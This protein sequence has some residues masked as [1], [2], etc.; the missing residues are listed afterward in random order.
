MQ[1][2]QPYSFLLLAYLLPAILLLYLLKRRYQDRVISS[3][4][5]WQ[6]LFEDLE[7]NRPWKK[8][9]HHLLLWLQLLVAILLVF[10]LSRPSLPA[11]TIRTSS[12]IIVIDISG[13]MLAKEGKQT[14]LEIARQKV[15]SFIDHK[16][17]DQQITLIAAGRVPRLLISQ[18]D[19]ES[20]LMNVLDQLQPELGS[21]DLD[22]ALSFA[23]ALTTATNQSEIL[24]VSDG[25]SL[26]KQPAS[27][28]HRS[29]Q[30]GSAKPNVAI[31]ASSL[32]ENEGKQELFVRV[33]QYG[34][35]KNQVA[36]SVHDLQGNLLAT[37]SLTMENETSQEVH[38]S[39]LPDQPVYQLDI[40]PIYDALA[41]DN[42]RYQMKTFQ[43]KYP[44]HMLG[45]PSIFLQKVFS[46]SDQLELSTNPLTSNEGF[47]VVNG[48]NQ[49]AN[50]PALYFSTQ[51]QGLANS[52]SSIHTAVSGQIE[53]TTPHMIGEGL[54]FGELSVANLSPVR[55]P[56]WADVILQIEGKPL[57]VA[58]EYQGK[59]VVLF[60]FD[61]EKSDLALKPYFPVLMMQIAHWLVP[62]LDA[63]A[64]ESVPDETVE[65]KVPPATNEIQLSGFMQ[66]KR[67]VIQGKV[68]IRLPE[69]V[70]LLKMTAVGAKHPFY[71][72]RVG[73]PEN[74]SNLNLQKITTTPLVLHDQTLQG[75]QEFWWWLTWLVIIVVT[76]EWVVFKRGY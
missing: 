5:L 58:G 48:G 20:E 17:S 24:L 43:K 1:V 6:R 50:Q 32:E 40:R 35:V 42:R 37:Q 52:K 69:A 26:S 64:K 33:D 68:K 61:L 57:L 11:D 62:E 8:F 65:V 47:S 38:F 54:N 36:V 46:L 14:R 21:S 70:G 59:R 45:S 51:L 16:D 3:N 9:Q 75:K 29:I 31:G 30:I 76:W 41:Q 25:A 63:G 22:A 53:N 23:H 39:Q 18:S 15:R 19:Q 73:F 66:G 4:L 60:P 67:R 12:A 27:L 10:A 2:L 55:V 71:F 44:V 49:W 7:A 72:I 56:D 13:S 28:P 34:K 74:E